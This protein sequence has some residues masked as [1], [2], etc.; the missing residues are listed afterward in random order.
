MKYFILGPK[1]DVPSVFKGSLQFHCFPF[2]L[3][4]RFVKIIVEAIVLLKM[5]LLILWG[6]N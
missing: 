6:Q 2:A 5:Q 4:T 1:D 3:S